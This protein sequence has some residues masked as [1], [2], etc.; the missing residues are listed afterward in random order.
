M[1]LIWSEHMGER[2][3]GAELEEAI[4]EAAWL[5]LTERGYAGLTM[6]SVAE[7]AGTSRPV[8]AR[9]WDGK[10]QLAISAIRQQMT[11]H[12]VEVPDRGNLRTELLEFLERASDRA[13]GVAA[14][15]T[16]FSSEYFAETSSVPK[17]LR[18]ALIHGRVQSLPAILERAVKRGE[19]DP[20]KLVPPVAFL[21]STLFREHVI[22][23]FSAPP[24]ALRKAWV[25]TVFLPLVQPK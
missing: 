17:D 13:V 6:E 21:L 18:A 10:A 24:P 8:L 19:V 2:R 11:K 4:L 15:F 5:E 12:P 16:L 9:R 14:A 1:H 3:R 23:N 25:D 7:R 20:Q 22:M